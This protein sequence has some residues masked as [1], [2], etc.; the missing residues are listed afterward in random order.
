MSVALIWRFLCPICSQVSRRTQPAT[1]LLLRAKLLSRSASLGLLQDMMAI[2]L[3]PGS[4]ACQAL[5]SP[6]CVCLI[7]F[8]KGFSLP[9]VLAG[10]FAAWLAG[11][12]VHQM[13]VK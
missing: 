8:K 3:R 5:S 10:S 2:I 9:I 4:M 7:G 12:F 11:A 13:L 1:A 6:V